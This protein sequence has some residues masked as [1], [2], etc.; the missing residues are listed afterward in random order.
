VVGKEANDD[1]RIDEDE[2]SATNSKQSN[3]R[4]AMRKYDSYYLDIGFSWNGDEEGPWPQRVV[5][6]E[7]LANSNRKKAPISKIVFEV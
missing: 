1:N 3:R 2:P 6:C 5:C 4:K 7:V